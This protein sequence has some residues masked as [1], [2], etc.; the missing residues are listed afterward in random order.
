MEKIKI[1]WPILKRN[2][3]KVL[4]EIGM[5][6]EDIKP[7]IDQTFTIAAIMIFL[8][9]A[10]MKSFNNLNKEERIEKWNKDV[11]L[12]E[13]FGK[14]EKRKHVKDVIKQV[15]VVYKIIFR[16]KLKVRIRPQ[17]GT[18]NAENNGTFFSKNTLTL[19]PNWFHKPIDERA[20]I[21]IHEFVHL[22]HQD[23]KLDGIKVYGANLAR[24][25]AIEKP[26]KAR[27]SAENYE[28]YCL[29]LYQLKKV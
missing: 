18:F 27:K 24:R 9:R 21:I 3:T 22:W 12:V 23:Q 19:F 4:T 29:E 7:L 1:K 26:N 8:A 11:L 5:P 20:S 6:V 28:H 10:E 2:K 17:D 15:D 16:N 13:W 25:L 14:T